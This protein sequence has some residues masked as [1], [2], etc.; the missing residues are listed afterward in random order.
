MAIHLMS[1]S[2]DTHPGE[3]GFMV[4]MENVVN[5]LHK[6]WARDYPQVNLSMVHVT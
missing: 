2:S 3:F 1:S 6:Q 4:V 5:K